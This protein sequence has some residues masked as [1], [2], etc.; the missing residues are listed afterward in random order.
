MILFGQPY[1]FQRVEINVAVDSSV[2]AEQLRGVEPRYVRKIILFVVVRPRELPAYEVIPFLGGHRKLLILRIGLDGQFRIK[3]AAVEVG[4]DRLGLVCLIKIPISRDT[5]AVVEIRPFSPA[6]ILIP[7]HALVELEIPQLIRFRIRGESPVLHHI[8]G[9]IRLFGIDV[10]VQIHRIIAQHIE[11]HKISGNGLLVCIDSQKLEIAAVIQCKSL[12]AVGNRTII[13]TPPLQRI[14]VFYGIFHADA[15]HE[16]E[17]VVLSD[18]FSAAEV[19]A[20]K[21]NINVSRHFLIFILRIRV[22]HA[23]RRGFEVDILILV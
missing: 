7:I 19:I 11:V 1:G 20:R 5:R 10:A 15:A 12:C 9:V 13:I 3:R 23:L 8:H 2:R 16:V 6:D 22:F 18:M 17:I 21:L 4:G 14:S